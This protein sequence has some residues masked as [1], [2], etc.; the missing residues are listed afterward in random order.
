M[1]IIAASST[2]RLMI[3]DTLVVSG[4]ESWRIY[5]AAKIVRSADG[6]VGGAAGL[7]SACAEFMRWIELG[8]DG[9]PPEKIWERDKDLGGLVLR[10]G[11][12]I[13]VY[14]CPIPDVVFDEYAAMGSG[15]VPC[16]AALHAGASLRRAVE[17]A[18]QVATGCG[19]ELQ[20]LAPAEAT[21]RVRRRA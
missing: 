16:L 1:T 11:G 13:E 6:S 18:C 12:R 20:E 17:I 2:E 3:A 4:S 19:G 14:Y 10:P 21:K 8:C 9:T 15:E 7:A 5:H